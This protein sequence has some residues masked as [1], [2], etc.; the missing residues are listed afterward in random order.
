MPSFTVKYYLYHDMC[1]SFYAVK[2][3]TTAD[4]GN[5][6]LVS[7]GRED[8]SDLQIVTLERQESI[9]STSTDYE[10]IDLN[11]PPDIA[12]NEDQRT[13]PDSDN[14]DSDLDVDNPD[15]EDKFISE[16]DKEDDEIFEPTQEYEEE[17]TR[18][19]SL[20][21]YDENDGGVEDDDDE[22][23]NGDHNDDDDDDVVVE[24]NEILSDGED[25]ENRMADD[26]DIEDNGLSTDDDGDNQNHSFL[27]KGG[28]VEN[29]SGDDVHEDL[30]ENSPAHSEIV[31]DE[32]PDS[33]NEIN[34]L[35]DISITI[36]NESL[37]AKDANKLLKLANDEGQEND[38][39]SV[40]ESDIEQFSD[41][42]LI[43]P[44]R[45]IVSRSDSEDEN[46]SN[47]QSETKKFEKDA[48]ITKRLVGDKKEEKDS[49]VLSVTASSETSKANSLTKGKEKTVE[50][51]KKTA[52]I[53]VKPSPIAVKRNSKGS[54]EGK[55]G[56]TTT[57]LSK[58]KKLKSEEVEKG[59]IAEKALKQTGNEKG[60]VQIPNKNASIKATDNVRKTVATSEKETKASIAE[61][62]GDE[63]MDFDQ[64][65]I[66]DED[67]DFVEEE[68]NLP[69]V[70]SKVGLNKIPIERS[71]AKRSSSR[72]NSKRRRRSYSS[73]RTLASSR[74]Y[75]NQSPSHDRLRDQRL[76]DRSRERLR[77]RSHSP[78]TR[79]RTYRG[80]Y[81]RRERSRSRER[82]QRIT[83]VVGKN[84]ENR[85]YRSRSRSRSGSRTRSSRTEKDVKIKSNVNEHVTKESVKASVK[86]RLEIKKKEMARRSTSPRKEVKS[87]DNGDKAKTVK[88]KESKSSTVVLVANG[89]KVESRPTTVTGVKIKQPKGLCKHFNVVYSVVVLLNGN[90]VLLL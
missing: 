38:A 63:Q 21:S 11:A 43:P 27:T 50:N 54:T 12:V 37:S 77:R 76:R 88:V 30:E 73:E 58:P 75:H 18:D 83:S 55:P 9:S 16:S 6:R 53:N 56:L 2:R 22:R 65:S 45:I 14:N 67:S 60:K 4:E 72:E 35:N 19:E 52:D 17:D 44:Q 23:Y 1:S 68:E 25:V 42:K 15:S 13:F 59:K 51:V 57:C 47:L 31:E 82:N 80:G 84:R 5:T 79:D 26:D 41:E 87:Q 90:F 34:I 40:P 20:E 64:L 36:A 3:L 71:R 28:N 10:E 86:E 46:D 74:S 29:V 32:P 69:V 48:V 49:A 66:E 70:K 39:K 81:G 8:K 7:L 85:H 61:S 78:L 24:D 89:A 33:D 62:K